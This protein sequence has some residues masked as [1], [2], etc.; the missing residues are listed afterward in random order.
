ME[1]K[2][3]LKDDCEMGK[4]TIQAVTNVKSVFYT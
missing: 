2:E 1:T 3:K 4:A